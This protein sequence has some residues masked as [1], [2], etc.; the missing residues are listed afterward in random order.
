MK[1]FGRRFLILV[2]LVLSIGLILIWLTGCPKRTVTFD[3]SNEDHVVE[4][5]TATAYGGKKA[6]EVIEKYGLKDAKV[7][8]KYSMALAEK[9]LTPEKWEKFIQKVEAKKAEMGRL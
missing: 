6:L 1:L 5:Y 8:E 7:M 9:A 4:I 3:P 2:S